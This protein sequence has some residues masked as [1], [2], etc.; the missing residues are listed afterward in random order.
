MIEL[1]FHIVGK[2]VGDGAAY[3]IGPPDRGL[4][5]K[6]LSINPPA[7]VTCSQLKG[8]QAATHLSKLL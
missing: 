2:G 8:A 7:K 1:Y 6:Q 5:R 3:F 4:Q